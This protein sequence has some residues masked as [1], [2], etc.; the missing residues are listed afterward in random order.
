MSGL[1]KLKLHIADP[2][3]RKHM[4]FLGGAVLA[5]IM[6]V[7]GGEVGGRVGGSGGPARGAGG[8]AVDVD[9][10][11]GV[12]RVLTA[13]WATAMLPGLV[14]VMGSARAAI[15]RPTRIQAAPH[16][17]DL[18]QATHLWRLL[19][20]PSPAPLVH[21]ELLLTTF[22]AHLAR[23]RL[24]RA[25]PTSGSRGRSTRRTRRGRCASAASRS[26]EDSPGW[27]H[28]DFVRCLRRTHGARVCAVSGGNQRNGCV[29]CVRAQAAWRLEQHHL[30]V[31]LSH[32]VPNQ[33]TRMAQGCRMG[34]ARCAGRWGSCQ[35]GRCQRRLP[36][37]GKRPAAAG[38]MRRADRQ[39]V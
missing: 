9:G 5:D 14:S 3:N 10:V 20:A 33:A 28:R 8:N 29:R 2:P 4:V 32:A 23:T 17:T 34:G 6:K 38:R 35:Q 15:G 27:L 31:P 21:L 30:A 1:R 18:A 7:R 39:A 22:P 19:P 37:A 12:C 24:R 36:G 16:L 26:T 13:F 11:Q 25:T